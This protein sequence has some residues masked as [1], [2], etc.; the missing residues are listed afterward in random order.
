MTQRKADTGLDFETLRRGI[1]RCDT[2]L[3]LGLYAHD[4]QL[5]IVNAAAPQAV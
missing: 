2:D 5:S 1:E 3:I 4:A